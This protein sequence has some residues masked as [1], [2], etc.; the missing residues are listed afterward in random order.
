[1]V[2]RGEARVRVSE[3]VEHSA[4]DG[5]ALL[6]VGDPGIGKWLLLQVGSELATELGARVLHAERV[7]FESD[8][9]HAVLDQLLV[10]A[11]QTAR[12]CRGSGQPP[13]PPLH[14]ARS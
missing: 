2:G 3:F 13:T 7:E 8:V 12:K 10:V 5:G 9:S 6:V 4:L 11:G 1:M 14:T